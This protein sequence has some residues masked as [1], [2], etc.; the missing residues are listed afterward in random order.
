MT[1]IYRTQ[2]TETGPLATAFLDEGMLIT[3]GADAPDELREFCFI[4][5]ASQSVA[6]SVRDHRRRRRRPAQPGLTRPCDDQAGRGGRGRPGR[7]DPR[8]TG[9][10]SART[11]GRKHPGDRGSVIRRLVTVVD[12]AGVHAQTAQKLVLLA[13]TFA[14]S[15]YLRR[16]GGTATLRDPISILALG[17][18]CGATVE[19]LADG[20]DEQAALAAIE[21]HL[22]SV[23]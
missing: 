20:A 6:P 8:R 17:L 13:K 2:V 4:V 15:L 22:G 21:A 19:I 18:A 11:E 10:G 3:F 14:S 12:P 16:E 7:S 9:S 5:T 23:H 1:E